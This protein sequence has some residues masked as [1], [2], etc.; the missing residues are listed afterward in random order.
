MRA[1][2]YRERRGAGPDV[3]NGYR[4]VITSIGEDRRVEITWRTKDRLPDGTMRTES[5]WMSPDDI[6]AGRLSLGY[7][8][9]VAASQGMTCDTGLLYGHGANAFAAYP[10]LT[11]G[12]TANHIWLPLDVVESERTREEL[13]AAHTDAERLDRAV[14]A[15]ATYLGQSRPDSMVSDELRPAPEPVT[16]PVP[17]QV[18]LDQARQDAQAA[19]EQAR[20]TVSARAARMRSTTTKSSLQHSAEAEANRSAAPAEESPE[21]TP[22]WKDRPYGTKTDEQLDTSVRT[23][24]REAKEYDAVA[25]KTREDYE[26][27][28]ERLKRE[29]A[30]GLTRGQKWAEEAGA[31]LDTAVAHL[32]TAIEEAGRV[33][34][35]D[36]SARQARAVLPDINRQMDASWLALRLAGSSRKEVQELRERY[37][38]QAVDGDAEGLRARRASD[39]ARKAAWSAVHD[40][41]FAQALGATGYAPR[42]DDLPEALAAMRGTLAHKGQQIDARDQTRLGHL[43]GAIRKAGAEAADWRRHAALAVTEQQR[44]KLLA[45]TQPDLHR[46]ETIARRAAA[47]AQQRQQAAVQAHPE[48]SA[49]FTPLQQEGPKMSR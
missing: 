24:L 35:A 34:W 14:H 43:S 49:T 8:M 23:F 10:G 18:R 39:D 9:T 13:G 38:T 45:T 36:E 41:P 19:V 37:F 4:G 16:A 44:R 48:P 32:R 29:G 17:H 11:R 30:E 21:E 31:V 1:N 40:S 20:R 12:R 7:A 26:T 25:A 22:S 15:F 27:L 47:D 28:R 42:P 6:A 5:A 3:L 2:D 33:R 46:A